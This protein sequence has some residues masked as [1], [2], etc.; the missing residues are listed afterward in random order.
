MRFTLP[1]DVLAALR[2]RSAQERWP[3]DPEVRKYG[4]AFL[5]YPGLGPALYLLED[6]RVLVDARGW[7][8]V[9]RDGVMKEGPI[10]E[11][12]D[13]EAVGALVVGARETGIAALL[14]LLPPAPARASPC[15]RCAG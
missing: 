4:E 13:D 6:G 9:Y 10:R 14:S 7:E 12:S 5:L 3:P 2:A 11:A 15:P 1:A 8:G